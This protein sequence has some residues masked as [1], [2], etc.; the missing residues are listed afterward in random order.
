MN[1][2][3]FCGHTDNISWNDV[4]IK[5]ILHVWNDVYE[6]S[7]GMRNKL[8]QKSGSYKPKITVALCDK[9]DDLTF[10]YNSDTDK[11]ILKKNDD[12]DDGFSTKII[13]NSDKYEYGDQ[14]DDP[15]ICAK[16]IKKY[17][18]GAHS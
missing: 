3:Q 7:H 2:C 14:N 4:Y 9:C 18:I 1:Y 17:K 15:E 16:N 12:N 5:N 8:I 6:K 13:I 10:L 11:Y